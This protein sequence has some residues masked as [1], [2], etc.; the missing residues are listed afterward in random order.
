QVEYGCC[1]GTCRS[2]TS[3]HRAESHPR[4][5]LNLAGARLAADVGLVH[6]NVAREGRGCLRHQAI[7][8]EVEHAPRGLVAHADLS[9]QL[10]GRDSAAS[11]GNQVDGVEPQVERRGRLVEDR[12]GGRMQV[13]AAMGA[14]PRLALL[15]GLVPFEHPALLALW[16]VGVPAV[17]GVASAPQVVQAGGIVGKLQ[18]ELHKRVPGLRSRPPGWSLSVACH[19][20]I[21]A[22]FLQSGDNYPVWSHVKT[23]P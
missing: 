18:R 2:L 19:S 13:M 3:M 10:L 1:L 7:A 11:A 20:R 14:R 15:S 23:R 4:H 22:P 12:P 21:I 5:R 6:L 17:R 16:A 9:L 8:D